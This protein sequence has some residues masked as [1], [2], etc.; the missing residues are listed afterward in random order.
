MKPHCLDFVQ[1]LLQSLSSHSNTIQ[2]A[3]GQKANTNTIS[4][5]FTNSQHRK[6]CARKKNNHLF[7]AALW[8]FWEHRKSR[9]SGCWGSLAGD[10]GELTASWM[11]QETHITHKRKSY[12]ESCQEDHV[13]HCS[14]HHHCG[15]RSYRYFW[16]YFGTNSLLRAEEEKAM[17]QSDVYS[18]LLWE[19]K[20]LVEGI[21][22]NCWRDFLMENQ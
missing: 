14:A 2:K 1:V 4:S 20:N 18:I 11:V 5:L 7:V 3:N 9:D 15:D 17:Y 22:T 10:D 13:H 6:L 8:G 16:R 12:F 19:R 21:F